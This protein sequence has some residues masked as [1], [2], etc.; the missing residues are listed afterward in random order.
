MKNNTT[1]WFYLEPYT[2]VLEGAEK[3]VVYNTLNSAYI[4][5]P[6]VK[7]L[8]DVVEA[9]LL[10]DSGYCVGISDKHLQDPVFS[11]FLQE[12]RH[13]FSGDL[14]ERDA[15][16]G[17]PFIFKPILRLNDNFH[18][19]TV[20]ENPSIAANIL[21]YLNEVSI[22][23]TTSCKQACINCR[24]YY[25]QVP[26]CTKGDFDSN[27]SFDQCVEI[28]DKID[29]SGVGLVNLIGGDI[30]QYASYE[31]LC[32]LLSSYKI[33]KK[34]HLYYKNVTA[35]SPGFLLDDRFSA[36]I[37]VDARTWDATKLD[38]VAGWFANQEAEYMFVVRSEDEFMHVDE[39]TEQHPSITASIKP[40]YDGTNM[41]F[42]Q[43]FVFNDLNDLLGSTVDKRTIFRRQVMNENFFGKLSISANGDVRTTAHA[44]VLGN[45]FECSLNELVFK[46]VNFGESWFRTRNEGA[47]K[48]CCN[49][50]LCASP[51]NYE[52][53]LKKSDLCNIRH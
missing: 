48:D 9:L 34:L 42:F 43:E 37:L 1:H 20:E 2:F 12:V 3:S 38:D 13:S 10:P 35:K 8:E 52:L 14:V 6:R 50:F 41:S 46:E 15:A 45:I 21:K 49:K 32:S 11:S 18:L 39:F 53:T 36:V 19:K 25:K 22:Q 27:L 4:T 33:K 23:L 7:V 5:I 51:S 30:E 31:E 28:L 26:F 17:K 16:R 47:C 24:D 29:K 44:P 40:F